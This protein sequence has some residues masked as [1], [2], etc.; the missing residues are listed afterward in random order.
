MTSM[1][2]GRLDR[3]PMEA[4]PKLKVRVYGLQIGNWCIGVN[5]D[6]K[7]LCFCGIWRYEQNPRNY[8]KDA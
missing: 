7:G 1:K 8:G 6:Y 2:I 3:K 5:R 4:M